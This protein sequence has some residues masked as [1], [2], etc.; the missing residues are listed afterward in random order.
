MIVMVDLRVL[1]LLNSRLCHEL[2]SPV[3]AINNGI[4]LMEEDDPDFVKDAMKLVANSARTAGN[5]LT[6]N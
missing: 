6:F 3:G 2:I 5:R 4:E 1:E